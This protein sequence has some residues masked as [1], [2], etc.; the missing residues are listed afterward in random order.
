MR[1]P[2]I[3]CCSLLFLAAC[4]PEP[5]PIPAPQFEADTLDANVAI[6]YGLA[7]GDMDGDGDDDIIL[8]DKKEFAWYR[9]G[10]WARFVI[11][12]DLTTRDNV[13]IAARDIDGDGM[14]EIAVGAMWNPGETTDAEQSGSVHY[15]MRPEN[16]T[17][18]WE[19]IPLPHEPT[20]HRMRWVRIA[21][22]S[23]HLVVAP[24]HGR[25]NEGGEGAGVQVQAYAM[26]ENP[27]DPW[28]IITID[29]QMHMTHNIAVVETENDL[30]A[31]LYIAGREGIRLAMSTASG[32]PEEGATA[33]PTMIHG[34]EARATSA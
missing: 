24:L 7:V 32:W 15:L 29:D 31:M 9:N 3:A 5:P 30:A 19:A 4:Q 22:G 33:I 8:A 12:E 6:G 21:D 34:L 23:Y 17:D 18:R 13:C 11:A 26:P 16:P 10:D 2:L 20:V 28:T 25:G 14:V 27:R 1:T